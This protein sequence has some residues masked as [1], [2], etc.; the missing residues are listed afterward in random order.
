[1]EFIA[2]TPQD[3]SYIAVQIKPLIMKYQI[4]A[5][6]GAMGAGKTTFI[7]SIV[8]V[9]GS[10]SDVSSPTFSLVNE[11]ALPNDKFI[12][13]FD[14]YRI[15]DIAEVYDM[16]YEEYFYSNHLC[17]IEWPERASE[18]LPHDVLN[19]KIEVLTGDKRRIII[20]RPDAIA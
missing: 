16:G 14:F 2:K 8:Q 4:T 6:Y 17:L 5:F 15:N 20:E 18:I 7:K 19:V 13:H 3:L 10:V 9:L 12:F 11:Y 1:M